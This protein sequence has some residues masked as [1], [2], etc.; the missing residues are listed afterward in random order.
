[1]RLFA[2]AACLAAT[3]LV[4]GCV[5]GT[6]ASSSASSGSTDAATL[7]AEKCVQCHG[8]DRV[9]SASKDRAGWNMTVTR[10]QS[11]G[12]QVTGAEK[13]AIL[14]YLASGGASQ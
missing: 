4:S 1:M 10:M 5:A 11:H 3:V 2:T 7:V 9:W 8:L 14:D 12:L 6:G 13:N